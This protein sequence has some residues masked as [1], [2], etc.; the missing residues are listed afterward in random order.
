MNGNGNNHIAEMICRLVKDAHQEVGQP[1]PSERVLATQLGCSRTNLRAALAQLERQGI[2]GRF[3]GKGTFLVGQ[4]GE[5]SS[6]VSNPAAVPERIV[7]IGFCV[8]NSPELVDAYAKLAMG[9]RSVLGNRTHL[10]NFM[11]F[12]LRQGISEQEFP[13]PANM[14]DLF[15]V[16]GDYTSADI[17]WF[18]KQ[19]KPVI[20]LGHWGDAAKCAIKIPYLQLYHDH[21]AD[22][23][24]VTEYLWSLGYR[25]PAMLIAT[26]HHAY[27]ERYKGFCD[28]LRNLGQ[29]PSQFKCFTIDTHETHGQVS[30]AKRRAVVEQVL[31]ARGQ[32]DAL[33][34]GAYVDV[35]GAARR[36]HLDI[37]G[38]FALVAE[39]FGHNAFIEELGIT[40]LRAD[41]YTFGL[42]AG[43]QVGKLSNYDAANQTHISVP[44]ELIV[45][46]STP[47]KGGAVKK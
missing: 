45:R 33:I 14:P 8:M 39:T 24:R 41:H 28:A 31:Q 1:L 11:L 4:P 5:P 42:L 25:K 44:V 2:L 29:E 40:E 43:Q 21:R 6:P 17:V 12:N 22:Y 34:T 26:K 27:M 13:A 16:T 3:H 37:P 7:N 35:L 10:I 36:H 32:F 18:A 23:A 30:Q 38:D 47:P 19:R 20:F 15:V 46:D 9:M